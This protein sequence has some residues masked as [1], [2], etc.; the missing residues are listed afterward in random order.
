MAVVP[1][2]SDTLAFTY[3]FA[4]FYAMAGLPS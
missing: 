1:V 3:I 2:S 4:P